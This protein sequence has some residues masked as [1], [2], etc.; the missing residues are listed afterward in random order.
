[1]AKLTTFLKLKNKVIAIFV[2]VVLCFLIVIAN[3]RLITYEL[4]INI[5]KMY[6]LYGMRAWNNKYPIDYPF[7]REDII[8]E[9]YMKEF[10]HICYY[11]QITGDN[12]YKLNEMKNVVNKIES[13]CS[14]N[15]TKQKPRPLTVLYPFTKEEDY[16]KAKHFI[17]NKFPFVMRGGNWKT[18]KNN[19]NIESIINKYGETTVYFDQN[20]DTFK[21]KLKDI[22]NHKAY[23]SNST[24]FMKKH[25]E[26]VNS[27]DI[28]TLKKISGLTPTISQIFLSLVPNNGTP[29]HSAFSHNFFFMVEGRKKWTFWHPDYLCLVYPYF[30]E[31]G[32]YFASASGIRDTNDP[33]IQK[34]FRLL[35]Y[36]P[37]Y[38]IILEEGDMLYNPGPWWHAIKNMSETSLAFATRWVYPDIFPSPNQLQYCQIVN[39]QIY[40]I[41]KEIYK[42]TGSFNF[43][44]DENYSGDMS[45]DSTALIEILNHDS[46]KQLDNKNR[47]HDW[48]ESFTN[49]FQNLFGY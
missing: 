47:F 20:N 36:A 46:L 18:N 24:S 35:Q 14:E 39:P 10:N 31:S 9:E 26:I 48:H 12:Q 16:A 30:P 7:D 49:M 45:E 37:S 29:M 22:R 6:G 2:I 11:R 8:P 32:I 33:N 17:N 28:D 13:Y 1:M 41:F 19:V 4:L 42:N 44:V 15:L 5:Y 34:Q 25:P 43:D 3:R 40:K 27:E 21:G 38:E 23:L